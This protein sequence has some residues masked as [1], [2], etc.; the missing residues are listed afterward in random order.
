MSAVSRRLLEG[1]EYVVV[2]F[3]FFKAVRSAGGS[4]NG[5]PAVYC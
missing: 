4:C 5:P 2:T 3:A 1:V